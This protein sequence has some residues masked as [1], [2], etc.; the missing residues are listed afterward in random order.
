[1]D[2]VAAADECGCFGRRNRVVPTPRRWRQVL[3]R[4]FGETTV[5]IKPGTPGRSRIS[6]N[7]I[8]QGMPACSA[9]P[10][11]LTRV[12]STNAHEAAGAASIR[13]SLRPP[14]QE[15]DCLARLGQIMPRERGGSPRI[16]HCEERSDEATQTA[17][18]GT[19]WIASR[20]LS[21]G[22]RSRDPLARN[23]G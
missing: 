3:P 22:A 4:R 15:G 13:H 21:S 14:L 18:L 7:T 8:V 17:S 6:R 19:L 23:D 2:G 11:F 16:R 20:S 9:C 12:L 5:A 1:M 10:R